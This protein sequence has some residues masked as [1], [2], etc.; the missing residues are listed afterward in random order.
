[1][2]SLALIVV[3]IILSAIFFAGFSGFIVGDN[4]KDDSIAA[5]IGIIPAIGV[6]LMFGNWLMFIMWIL[7]YYMGFS[8]GRF[9]Q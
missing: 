3:L 4:V 8:I 5:V 2:E 1:M 6:S 7:S 9:L